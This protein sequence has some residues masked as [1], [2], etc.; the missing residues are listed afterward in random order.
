M[1]IYYSVGPE[2]KQSGQEIDARLLRRQEALSLMSQAGVTKRIALQEAISLARLGVGDRLWIPDESHLRDEVT[3]AVVCAETIAVGKSIVIGGQPVTSDAKPESAQYQA[4]E[5][6]L[7]RH[8]LLPP[9]TGAAGAHAYISPG[10]PS[11]EECARMAHKLVCEMGYSEADVA[12]IFEIVDGYERPAVWT[13][14]GVNRLLWEKVDGEKY[15]RYHYNEKSGEESRRAGRHHLPLA[16]FN[17]MAVLGDEGAETAA[18]KYDASLDDSHHLIFPPFDPQR[19]DYGLPTLLC[20]ILDLGCIRTL[21]VTSPEAVFSSPAQRHVLYDLALFRGVKVVENGTHV[22]AA[23]SNPS[24]NRLLRE[25]TALFA[26]LRVRDNATIVEE[27]RSRAHARKTAAEHHR[28]G[29]SLREI[30]ALLNEEAIPTRSGRGAWD[31]S[32][33]KEL[34]ASEPEADR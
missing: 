30:A 24:Y 13:R 1:D 2:G 11:D 26:T 33:V 29:C 25:G 12:R 14:Q 4:Y 32:A 19:P 7:E 9:A 17:G 20:G 31:A 6:A 23:G 10:W 16:T 21:H 3:R 34:L 15:P 8:R 5:A 18:R 22:D 28:Q 27:T